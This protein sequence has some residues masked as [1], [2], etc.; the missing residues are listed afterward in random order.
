[1]L[2]DSMDSMVYSLS[3][4]RSLCTGAVTKLVDPCAHPCL[5]RFHSQFEGAVSAAG[6]RSLSICAGGRHSCVIRDTFLECWGDS[7]FE[8]NGRREGKFI[9][10]DCG[11]W[12]TCALDQNGSALCFGAG[13]IS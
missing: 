12:H 2:C 11:S 7:E 3:F 8:N 6:G 13:L 4:C 1:M 10:V 5:R 9:A